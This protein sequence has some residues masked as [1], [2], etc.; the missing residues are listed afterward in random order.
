MQLGYRLGTA[1]LSSFGTEREIGGPRTVR[2]APVMAV[3][4]DGAAIAAWHHV[5]GGRTDE[6]Q[7]VWRPAGGHFGAIVTLAHAAVDDEATVGVGIDTTGRAVVAYGR[8]GDIAVRVISRTGVLAAESR[9]S[10]PSGYHRPTEITVGTGD[11]G[12][13]VVAWRGFPVSEGPTGHVDA[14]AAVL[15]LGQ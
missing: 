3:N 5:R 6:I 14:A 9:R 2:C 7:A 8:A 11:P 4:A 1:D 12:N 10:V 15:P 13:V